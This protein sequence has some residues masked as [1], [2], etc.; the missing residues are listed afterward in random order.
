MAWASA[1]AASGGWVPLTLA[2]LVAGALVARRRRATGRSWAGLAV[3]L[4]VTGAVTCSTV[5][6]SEAVAAGPV[7]DLAAANAPVTAVLVLSSDPVPSAG[8]FARQAWARA[9]VREVRSRH[10]RVHVRA[11]V[12]ALLPLPVAGL[13]RGTRVRVAGSL[14]PSDRRE[15]AGVLVVRGEITVLG[16]PGLLE[17]AAGRVRAGVREGV[18]GQPTAARALVPALVDGEDGDLPDEVVADF[19]TS[20]MTHLLAVSG[21]NLTLIVGCLLLVAR[22]VGVRARALVVVGLL[23]VVGFVLLA[24]PEPSVLRAAAMGS[25]ALLGLSSGGR[26]RGLRALGIGVVV[27]LLLDPGLAR[28]AGFALSAIAT[29]GILLLAPGWRDALRRWL[30]RWA[31]EAISV[32]LA[33]QLVCTPVVAAISG[34]VSLVAVA[35][36]LVAGPLVAPATVLGLAGGLV[37]VVAPA[38]GRVVAAPAGWCASGLVAVASHAAALPVPSI[39]WTPD[40][41]S[42]VVLVA[43]CGGIG[44]VLPWVLGRRRVSL[45]VVGVL[46]LAVLKPLPTPGWPPAGWVLVACS[47]GQ[48][49][50]LV[51]RTG[52]RSGLVVDAGPDPRAMDQCL[53]RLEIEEVPVVFLT[54]FHADHV[55]GL[56]GVL[57][58]R[59]VGAVLTSPLADPAG[60]AR[61]VARLA[62]QHRIGVRAVLVGESATVGQVQWQVLAPAS[63]TFSDSES[64]PNDASVVLLAD[65]RGVRILLM[66]DQER[67]SQAAL[68]RTYPDLHADVLKVAHHGSSKQDV[69]LIGSLGARL[70]LI[71]D[72]VDNDYGHPA[73]STLDLLSDAG[74]QVH[75]T[76]REGDLAVVV[77]DGGRLSVVSRGGAVGRP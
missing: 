6:G 64:P 1:L 45:L 67:P 15:Q 5:L 26:E 39:G 74:L 31:A 40:L 35:A 76:D 77:G 56:A 25:I 53:S 11:P 12:L 3:A 70:A 50:G 58:G 8:R 28:S 55:D 65:V 41:L 33:A 44:C 52:A 2:A 66:G 9:E 51:L 38:P 4:L 57:E 42:L 20:G 46:T 61:A 71:S 36:N 63:A 29:G 48:G 34:Q 21:T 69:R 17:R 23:G 59:R 18:S 19:R 47:I 27:L 60:G 72:G 22:W 62:A 54:H 16:G 7:H 75:R 13:V 14:R 32:P 10:R 68:R 24:G 37:A 43:A 30:P 49:D 73:P